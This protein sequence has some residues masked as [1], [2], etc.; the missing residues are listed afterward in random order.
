MSNAGRS[1]MQ[2]QFSAEPSDTCAVCTVYV[3]QT[4]RGWSGVD[5]TKYQAICP[6]PC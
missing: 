5:C 3:N 6:R 1:R 2:R 4:D